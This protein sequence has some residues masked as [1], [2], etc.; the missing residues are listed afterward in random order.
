MARVVNTFFWRKRR[1]Y[2]AFLGVIAWGGGWLFATMVFCSQYHKEE[3]EN[4]RNA[5]D[6]PEEVR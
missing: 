6:R 4:L 3:K 2:A 5:C 1:F